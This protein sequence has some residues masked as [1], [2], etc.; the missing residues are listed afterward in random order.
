[1]MTLFKFLFQKIYKHD[2]ETK[3]ALKSEMFLLKKL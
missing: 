3:E 2:E 1:M